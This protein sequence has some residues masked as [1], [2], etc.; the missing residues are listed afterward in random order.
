[1]EATPRE[2][3]IIQARIGL[4]D[5]VSII[6]GIIIGVGIF[7]VPRDV[8]DNVPSP[9]LALLVWGLGGSLALVGAFCFAE[10]ATT[11]P[12]SG[13]EY[14]YLTRAYGSRIGLLYAWAQLTV[15]RPGSIAAV[16]YIFANSFRVW[17]V[18][19]AGI[20]VLAAGSIAVLSLI[21]I[22]G[23][24]LGKHTQNLLTVL[25]VLGLVAI[26]VTG[27]LWSKPQAEPEPVVV[28]NP[29]FA[30]AMIFALWAYSGWHE[31]AYVAA[32]VKNGRRN[33]PVA[34]ILGTAA[35]TVIYLLVNTAIL[36]A[37]GFDGA[38]S[39]DTWAVSLLRSVLGKSAGD[40]INV[41]VMVSALGA[42]NGMIFTTARIYAVFGEDHP[43][44]AP[45]G[46][47]SRRWGTPVRALIAQAVLSMVLV[48]GVSIL[49]QKSEGGNDGFDILVDGTAPVFW[50]FFLLT[51]IALFILRRKDV[52]L[53]RPFRVPAY[54]ILPMV[55]CASCGY[56]VF[57]SI[58]SAATYS[59][60]GLGILLAGLPLC[61]LPRS[62]ER[63]AKSDTR[64]KVAEIIG[65]PP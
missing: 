49:W 44:F 7:R 58:V 42:I 54:P 22:L 46:R 12:R 48:V 63:T 13:G 6:I 37:L 45:L 1:M 34:L 21:N 31:A 40:A 8:F 33:L 62:A 60:I 65:P 43:V 26:A 17:G 56:M 4:W 50:L 39:T 53:P 41:A 18:G 59:L 14:V 9:W 61:F 10:L 24:T 64:E 27:F 38:R 28:P 52:E 16:A 19:A 20:V 51:G 11:Y 35:V 3:E 15:I 32:E 23:V 57:G 29:S 55:F 5:A 25:K 36:F 2:P 47:W 30:Q